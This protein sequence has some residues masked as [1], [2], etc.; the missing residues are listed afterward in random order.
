MAAVAAGAAVVGAGVA[1]YGEIESGQAKANAAK[2]DAQLKNQQADELMSRE[3]NNEQLIQQQ[4]ERDQKDYG[5]AFAG[6]GRE[7]GGIG[8][9]MTI[10]KNT[11]ITIANSQRDAEFKA[12]ML[13]AGANIATNLASD[14]VN[15]SYIT[16]AGTIITGAAKLSPSFAGASSSVASIPKV[17]S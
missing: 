5:A 2:L 9:I 11:A 16:G 13:R 1:I 14:E 12:K 4:S 3:A 7:G 8:G 6:S 15:A 10:Q 17:P